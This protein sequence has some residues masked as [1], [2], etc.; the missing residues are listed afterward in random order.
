[1]KQRAIVTNVESK[2]DL[3]AYLPENYKVIG[4]ELGLNDAY[5]IEGEDMAGW[6]L[7]DYVVPRLASGMMVATIVERFT[8]STIQADTAITES[9]LWPW[10]GSN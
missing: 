9:E 5:V 1:M 7:E 4:G 6:T 2:E 3:E 10:E 8:G